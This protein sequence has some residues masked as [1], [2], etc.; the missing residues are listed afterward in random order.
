M[1]A[2]FPRLTDN[3]GK[4]SDPLKAGIGA[5]REVG[6]WADVIRL[7]AGIV[8]ILARHTSEVAREVRALHAE[9]V[10]EPESSRPAGK[11]AA[12]AAPASNPDPAGST[13]APEA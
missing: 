4:L 2:T 9:V 8:A 6:A 7:W 10:G 1:A 11:G 12:P 3:G 13:P 5:S